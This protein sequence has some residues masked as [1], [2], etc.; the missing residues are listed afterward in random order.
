MRTSLETTTE[1]RNRCR[2]L[3]PPDTACTTKNCGLDRGGLETVKTDSLQKKGLHSLINSLSRQMSFC[4][5]Q[6]IKLRTGVEKDE[7][8][9]SLPSQRVVILV[10]GCVYVRPS[11][12]LL[13]IC[14]KVTKSK[15]RLGF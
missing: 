8:T 6:A 4:P 5:V 1:T 9:C 10:E 13:V 11:R 15:R 7:W 2:N 3:E 14:R 12:N